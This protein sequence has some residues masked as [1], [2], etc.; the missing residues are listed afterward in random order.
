MHTDYSRYKYESAY[1]GTRRLL[2]L[3]EL[4]EDPGGGKLVDLSVR[5]SNGRAILVSAT[6]DNKREGEKMAYV[7]LQGVRLFALERKQPPEE[8]LPPNYRPPATFDTA[9]DYARRLSVGIDY[10]RYDFLCIGERIYAGEITVYPAAGMSKADKDGLDRILLEGWDILQSWF[11]T[12][13][14]SGWRGFYA[15]VVRRHFMSEA[16]SRAA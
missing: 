4:I 7:D 14:Q 11:L 6:V 1:F 15:G 8:F 2:F 3:E 5:C 12:T 16:P 13:P 9:V 10:A